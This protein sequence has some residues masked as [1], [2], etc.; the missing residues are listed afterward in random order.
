MGP[1][2]GA[3]VGCGCCW[4]MASAA[5]LEGAIALFRNQTQQALSVQQLLD[6]QTLGNG[7]EDVCLVDNSPETPPR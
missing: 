7:I 2:L 6:C 3:P 1:L 5:V 4:A